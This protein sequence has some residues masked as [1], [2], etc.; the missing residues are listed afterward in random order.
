AAIIQ[1]G[2]VLDFVYAKDVGAAGF[3]SWVALNGNWKGIPIAATAATLDN[4]TAAVGQVGVVNTFADLAGVPLNYKKM[5]TL[6]FELVG[7][8]HEAEYILVPYD[9]KARRVQ[10]SSVDPTK[11]WKRFGR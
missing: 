6:G 9:P 10:R 8:G 11:M 3:P 4:L 7:D 1:R 5:S 2:Y